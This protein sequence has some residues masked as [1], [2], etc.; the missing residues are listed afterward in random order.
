MVHPVVCEDGAW[1]ECEYVEGPY[2]GDED[3]CEIDEDGDG[4]NTGGEFDPLTGDFNFFSN[5]FDKFPPG[6]Y[7]FAITV[8]VG[9]A[10]D[11]QTLTMVVHEPC[12][13]PQ[14]TILSQPQSHQYYHL[15][16]PSKTIFEFDLAT[17]VHTAEVV[18]CGVPSIQ[19]VTSLNMP[20]NEIFTLEDGKLSVA[21]AEAETT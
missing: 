8:H 13:I 14:M 7:Q 17:I 10:F 3:L 1:Y 12:A 20:L 9:D 6:N 2:E 11:T 16:A 18:D 4:T 15:G 21:A 5:D 19:F